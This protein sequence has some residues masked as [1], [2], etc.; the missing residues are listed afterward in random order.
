MLV[1]NPLLSA[2]QADIDRFLSY[3][4]VLPNGCWFWAGARSR[5]KGNKKWYGSF[6][7]S[8]HGTVRAHRFAAEVLGN[9]HCPPGHHRDHICHFSLCVNPDHIEIVT[10]CENEKRK[11]ERRK[12][13]LG[14]CKERS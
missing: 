8:G 1:R 13:A 10:H 4:D 11:Q 12:H 2:T 9:S 7:L 3:V 5:G 14:H 6:H